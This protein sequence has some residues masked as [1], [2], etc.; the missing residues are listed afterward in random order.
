MSD[1]AKLLPTVDAPPALPSSTSKSGRF[2]FDNFETPPVPAATPI[3]PPVDLVAT[4]LNR[5]AEIERLR[6][7]RLQRQEKVSDSPPLRMISEAVVKEK[8]AAE[9][10]KERLRETDQV[11]H[12]AVGKQLEQ[13]HV[14]KHAISAESH[15][16][17]QAKSKEYEEF[18]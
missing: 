14:D 11:S 9:R 12:L 3:A 4:Q 1:S 10:L 15:A 13:V 6:A 7:A 8:S 2:T 17:E 16:V 18:Y 5:A